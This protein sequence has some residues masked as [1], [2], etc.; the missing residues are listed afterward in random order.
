MFVLAGMFF[1]SG[2]V[3]VGPNFSPPPV[4]LSKN[5]LEGNDRRVKRESEECRLWWQVFGD[6]VLN[7]LVAA[8]YRGNLSLGQAGVRVLEARAQLGIAIGEWYPQQQQ[9]FGSVQRIRLSAHALGS[10]SGSPAGSL[11]TGLAQSAVQ[12]AVGSF[13]GRLINP[14]GGAAPGPAGTGVAQGGTGLFSGTGS[15]TGLP[16]SARSAASQRP[17]LEF[18]QSNLGLTASWEPDFWG[19]YR[20]GIESADAALM[21]S[22]ADY[23]N[24]LVSLTADA[25][26]SYILIRTLERRILIARQNVETQQ[27]S[28]EIAEARF[29]GGTTSERDVQQAKTQ[30]LGTQAA[31]PVLEYQLRQAKNALSVLLGMPPGPL[32]DLLR[33]PSNIPVPPPRVGVGI[34]ADLLRRRPD[35]RSAELQAA[36]Q[37]AQIG[38]AK[39]D[40]LPAFTLTGTFGFQSSTFGPS[41][42]DDMFGWRSRFGNGGPGFQ[43]NILN[44]GQITN[45]VRVQDAR[46]QELLINYQNMVLVAQREVEDALVA[47]LQTQERATLLAQS[48]SA[49]QRS[50]DLAVLQYRQGI[51]DFTTV[52]TAQQA[53][54]SEQDNLADTLGNIARNLVEVYRALGGGWELRAG[55][56]VVPGPTREMMAKRTDWGKLLEP[57]APIPRGP[58]RAKCLP[59]PP[60]W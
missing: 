4:S 40:L 16:G 3:T 9:G 33:G 7:R 59:P 10:S 14:V 57:G 11:Q 32:T 13:T 15:G 37:C 19:R 55:R 17:A 52:L 60:D 1:A 48:T 43:W 44:Y 6:P 24:A 50:L 5:W 31:I 58:V 20:R 41:D 39:A 46:F 42:L 29:H 53:L 56:D 26:N 12:G 54:L 30:L 38:V 34:P 21:A 22:L 36:A 27:E 18:S 45:Q 8:A 51:T 25:A 35:I 2:C 47:F 49:A 28:L 23:D